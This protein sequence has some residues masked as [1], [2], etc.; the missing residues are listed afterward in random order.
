MADQPHPLLRAADAAAREERFSHPWNPRSE[1][2]GVRL[3]AAAGLAR[4]AVNLI[5]LAPGKE[6]FVYHRHHHE[7]EWMYVLAGRGVVDL[8]GVE[9]EV[10]LGDFLGFPAPSVAYHLRNPF[11]G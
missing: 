5:H 2:R 7:E 10:G 11:D 6:S 8:D 9:H 1:L 4:T 3:G